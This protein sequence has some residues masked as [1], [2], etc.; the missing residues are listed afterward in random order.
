MVNA[1][2]NFNRASSTVK[3]DT[4]T[5]PRLGKRISPSGVTFSFSNLNSTYQSQAGLSFGIYPLGNL[6]LYSF[7]SATGFFQGKG[8]GGMFKNTP[9]S[10][11]RIIISETIGGKLYNN[12]WGTASFYY[13]NMQNF[14]DKNAFVVYN[15][16]DIINYKFDVSLLFVISKRFD[17]SLTYGFSEMET[18]L[19]RYSNTTTYNSL[20][21]V[22]LGICS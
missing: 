18:P 8:I 12:L 7:T 10:D 15:T 9:Y 22:V 17:V 14:N 20:S 2:F 16:S 5:G 11:Q 4:L 3:P 19:L 6:D 13:G 1:F 21:T